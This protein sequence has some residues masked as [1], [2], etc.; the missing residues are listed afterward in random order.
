MN[1]NLLNKNS[2]KNHLWQA[3]NNNNII[4]NPNK[5]RCKVYIQGSAPF[6]FELS[7]IL[8]WVRQKFIVNGTFFYR[9]KVPDLPKCSWSVKTL[10]LCLKLRK[11]FKKSLTKTLVRNSVSLL[12]FIELT[13]IL[14]LLSIQYLEPVKKSL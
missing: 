11:L 4:N 13:L 3:N 1:V 8:T 10:R 2:I 7:L 5:K 6:L 14:I 9:K 12:F